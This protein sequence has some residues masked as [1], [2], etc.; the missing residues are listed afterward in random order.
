MLVFALLGLNSRSSRIILK[1]C[2]FPLFGG[3]NNSIL[4]VN[5]IAPTL[6]LFFNAE[7]ASVAAISVTISFL[8]LFLV[9][10]FFD[11]LTS[12]S[13]INVS[14]LSSSKI[15]INGSLYLAVTFQSID[16]ISSPNSYFLTSLKV[17]PLPLKV[18]K[19]SPPKTLSLNLLL[20]ISTCLT[21]LSNSLESINYGTSTVF[22]ICFITSSV[23]TLSASASYVKPILC[24]NTSVITSL[25]SSG[26]TNPLCL[27]KA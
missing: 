5:K 9:A 19:Y 14:S 7:N 13:N 18:L 15:L 25:T 4:S 10:K 6:S 8:S 27:I 23:V 22:I 17:I 1:I 26:I 12:I 2:F 3:I 24:L 16:L 11:P 20:F 21:F